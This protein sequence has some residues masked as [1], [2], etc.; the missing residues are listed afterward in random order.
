MRTPAEFS[1]TEC[2]LRIGRDKNESSERVV[3]RYVLQC[4]LVMKGKVKNLSH[5][6]PRRRLRGEKI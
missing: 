1:G 6:T 3:S 5:Y 2:F 4:V